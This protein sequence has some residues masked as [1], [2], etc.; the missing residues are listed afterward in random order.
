MENRKKKKNE[1][2]MWLLS[3]MTLIL[4]LTDQLTMKIDD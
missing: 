4:L 1:K 3:V 2:G